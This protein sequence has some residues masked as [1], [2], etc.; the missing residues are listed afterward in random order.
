M[1]ARSDRLRPFFHPRRVAIVGASEQGM[2]P[3]GILQSLQA[4]GYLGEIYPVNPR[5]TQVFGLP[6]Y[7]DL[8]HVPQPPDLAVI[9]IPRGEVVPVLRQCLAVG[10]PAACVISAGFAE[11]DE[12]GKALQREM[13]DLAAGGSLAVIGPNCAGLAHVP[14]G[15]IATKLPVVPRSGGVSFVSQSGAL[16]MALSGL[17]AD[18]RVGMN[19]LVSLGN[20]ADVTLAD[21]LAYLADD[22]GTRVAAAFL[23][24]VADGKAFVEGARRLLVA[25]KPLVLL[26]SGRTASGQKAA[27]TH[28]AALAGSERVFT[29][30]CRQLGVILVDDVYELVH[31]AALLDRFGEALVGPLRLAVVTQ[32]GGLG[33]LTA[34]LCEFEGLELPPLHPATQARLLEMPELMSFGTVSNP[35]DVRG[36]GVT[37]ANITRTLEPFLED[38]SSQMVLLLL[39][40][41]LDRPEDGAA[42]QA[43]IDLT[44][45]YNKPLAVVWVGGHYLFTHAVTPGHQVL[46]DNGVPVFE[47]PSD[48][49]RALGRAARYWAFRQ[50]WLTDPENP[51][52]QA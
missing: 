17:F 8:A 4:N 33:S 32:S 46:L 44:H 26:K 19:L 36:A 40:K 16:M 5:R 50:A 51:D 24:G 52:G 22:P 11:A 6:C 18:L 3:A 7:P 25:G 23:E 21:M 31:T 30:I 12:Q 9:T 45:R 20:Q 2:Y 49:V 37:A 38:P 48:C 39:A 1:S 15:L 13:A 10:V 47:Q 42:N 29:A 35:A 28:T 43:L 14:S 34:D 27:A 41:Q